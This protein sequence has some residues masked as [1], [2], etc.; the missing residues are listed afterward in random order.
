MTT[1]VLE[2]TLQNSPKTS[3]GP[4]AEDPQAKLLG[5]Y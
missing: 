4:Q 3:L 5:S 2:G 1:D